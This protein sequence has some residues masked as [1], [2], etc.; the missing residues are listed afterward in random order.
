MQLGSGEIWR[1]HGH[2]TLDGCIWEQVNNDHG[3]SDANT[4]PACT[5][6][7]L[8]KHT[9][10]F[11]DF[12]AMVNAIAEYNDDI[13][14]ATELPKSNLTG[15]CEFV[16]KFK[17]SALALV[18]KQRFNDLLEVFCYLC[19]APKDMLGIIG[20]DRIDS[21]LGYLDDNVMPCCSRCN[22]AKKDMNLTEF[23]G[24]IQR[25]AVHL[26]TIDIGVD[27]INQ[28][29][30]LERDNME[31][32][33]PKEHKRKKPTQWALGYANIT[34]QIAKSGGMIHGWKVE[35]TTLDNLPEVNQEVQTKFLAEFAKKRGVWGTTKSRRHV[36][37]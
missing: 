26:A 37:L 4:V 5:I 29:C 13:Q 14:A 35:K 16:D 11:D 33:A 2:T 19:G 32:P 24:H 31:V 20:V 6:C 23:L 15:T 28:A 1:R 25:M 18:Y 27:A 10:S 30:A 9:L 8:I 7:N 36:R 12:V 17:D 21:N 22:Y 3:Y 34:D